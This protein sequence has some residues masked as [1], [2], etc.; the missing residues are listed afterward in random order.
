MPSGSARLRFLFDEAL[1]EFVALEERQGSGSSEPTP[2]SRVALFPRVAVDETA[3]DLPHSFT[4]FARDAAEALG[5][6]EAP[7]CCICLMPAV[8]EKGGGAMALATRASPCLLVGD[9]GAGGGGGATLAMPCCGSI[10]HVTCLAQ[11]VQLRAIRKHCCACQ[12][13]FDA[14]VFE[15][16]ASAG[17]AI[18]AARRDGRQ[19]L[20]AALA[21]GLENLLQSAEA[22]GKADGSDAGT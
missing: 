17:A 13:P 21:A 4:L 20:H 2:T 18:T 12:A 15:Q 14:A 3:P 7:S 1:D 5:A 10:A 19:R 16:L 9:E 11:C 6:P 8:Q 22:G